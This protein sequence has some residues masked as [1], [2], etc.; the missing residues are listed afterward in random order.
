MHAKQYYLIII[1]QAMNHLVIENGKKIS[2][3]GTALKNNA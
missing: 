3:H 2:Q 1:V